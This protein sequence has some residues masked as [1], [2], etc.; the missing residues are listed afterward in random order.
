MLPDSVPNLIN[1]TDNFDKKQGWWIYSFKGFRNRYIA[2]EGDSGEFVSEY[3]YGKYIN[4]LQ[5]DNW[6]KVINVHQIFN[7]RV[8]NY[9][10][11]KDTILIKSGFYSGG[12]NESTMYYNSDSSIIIYKR[13]YDD[14]KEIC[15]TCDRK[16][17]RFEKS[18]NVTYR[19]KLIKSFPHDQFEIELEK[20]DFMY[21]REKKLI[22][23]M[24]DKV[25]N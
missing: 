11:G 23:L 9:Y 18:C 8:D 4:N 2:N 20:S 21:G 17:N 19:K 15:I 6:T 14:N 12:W 16:K 7:I 24:Y 13:N 22:D 1:C 25:K 5:V 3:I 10:Y